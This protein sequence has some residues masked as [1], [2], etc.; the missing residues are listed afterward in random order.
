MGFFK[1]LSRGVNKF[2]KHDI[3]GGAKNFFTQ[4]KIDGTKVI[5]KGSVLSKGLGDVSKG[6]GQAGSVLGSVGKVAGQVLN[7]PLV[8]TGLMALG[9]E[10]AIGANALTDGIKTGSQV[11]KQGSQLTNQKSYSGNPSQVAN[12]ILNR[13][14]NILEKAT[15]SPQT[16]TAYSVP[17]AVAVNA[18]SSTP[19][20]VA[21]EGQVYTML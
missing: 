5:G 15:N 14:S 11:L 6:L 8:Q 18:S 21:H 10:A 13:S 7:N 17:Q 20:A 2:F 3:G 12:Q 16:A 9:P 1:S 4:G 19:T